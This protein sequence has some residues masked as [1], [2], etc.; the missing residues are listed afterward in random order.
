VHLPLTLVGIAFLSA[1][2]AHRFLVVDVLR[3]MNDLD[4]FLQSTNSVLA[5]RNLPSNFFQ[6][7]VLGIPA[8]PD[9]D[10]NLVVRHGT[11]FRPRGLSG[12]RSPYDPRPWPLPQ[13]RE[14]AHLH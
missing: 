5:E 1:E 4:D 9:F 2:E 8:T 13:T 7:A 11:S 3:T 6:I 12:L 14:S 10:E